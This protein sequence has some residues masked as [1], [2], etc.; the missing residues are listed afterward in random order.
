MGLILLFVHWLPEIPIRSYRF[1]YGLMYGLSGGWC[2]E[3]YS[4][5]C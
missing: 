5:R 2:D 1:L 3:A 4:C